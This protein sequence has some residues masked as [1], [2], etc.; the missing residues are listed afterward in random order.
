M[1]IKID[2]NNL[3]DFEAGLRALRQHLST[4]VSMTKEYP[5]EC[6]FAGYRFVFANES[7]ILEVID[8]IDKEIKAYQRRAA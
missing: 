2:K 8:A 3:A 1:G 5:V 6:S 7:D 4:L